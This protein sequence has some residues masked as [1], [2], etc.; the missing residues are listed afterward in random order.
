MPIEVY[1]KIRDKAMFLKPFQVLGT[2]QKKI[3][4]IFRFVRQ[5]REKTPA[6]VLNYE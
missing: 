2:V 1:E 4:N 3:L 6:I 5:F